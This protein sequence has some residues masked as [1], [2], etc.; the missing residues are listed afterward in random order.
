MKKAMK[1]IFCLIE[2]LVLPLCA[3]AQNDSILIRDFKVLDGYTQDVP[4]NTKVS[5]FEKDSV[6]LLADSMELRVMNGEVLGFY[7]YVP[8][9]A[10]YVL[11]VECK[12]YPTEW[13]LHHV[14][15]KGFNNA[16]GRQYY[17]DKPLY[18]WQVREQDLAEA[19][20]T[21]SKVLMV[22]KGDTIEYSAAAFRMS[23]G[24]ML[25]N[26]VAAMPGMAIDNE[27][28][29]TMNGEFVKELL[30]NGRDFFKGDPRVALS[31]LPAYTVNKI[32][33]YRRSEERPW[34]QSGR[35]EQEKREDPLVMNVKLKREYEQGWLSNYELAGG[36]GL[37][38]WFDEKWLARLFA[39]RYTNHSSIAIY[40]NA[41]NLN[42]ASSPGRKGEWKRTD[43][44][45]GEKQ[46]YMAGVDFSLSPKDTNLEFNT[47][48]QALR[49]QNRL[50]EEQMREDFLSAGNTFTRSSKD[51]R[52]TFT[53]LKWNADLK[54]KG[55]V[56][57]ISLSPQ[58]YYQH[59]DEFGC[60]QSL[61]SR[62]AAGIDTLYNRVQQAEGRE[63]R[64]GGSL[65]LAS[66]LSV[67]KQQIDLSA[68]V[69]YNKVRSDELQRDQIGYVYPTRRSSYE[70]R[71]F[72]RPASDYNYRLK[73]IDQDPRNKWKLAKGLTFRPTLSYAFTQQFNSGHQD[74]QRSKADWLTPS[75]Q[76]D[77]QWAVDLANSFH[78]TRMER[79]HEITVGLKL[80]HQKFLLDYRPAFV[81][82]QR[83]INDFRNTQ[84]SSR[85]KHDFLIHHWASLSFR[86]VSFNATIERELPGIYYLLDVRDESDPLVHYR[87]NAGLKPTIR[88]QYWAETTFRSQYLSRI[89]TAKAGYTRRRNA[90]SMAQLFDRT[91]N[92]TTYRPFNIDGNWQVSAVADYSQFL[93][94]GSHWH[95]SNHLEAIFARSVDFV[96]DNSDIPARQAVRNLKLKDELALR[97]QIHSLRVGA[98]ARV[99][100]T[101]LESRQQL[102]TRFSY[103]DFSC[104]VTLSTPIFR[105]VNLDT[106][107]MAYCRRGYNDAAMNTTDWVWNISLD[108]TLGKHKQ[109]TL[110]ATGFDLLRQLSNTLRIVNAQG[111]VETR[112]NTMP[113]YAML[114]VMYRLDVLPK[115]RK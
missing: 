42:D 86:K 50:G 15:K 109:W 75:A 69:A 10:D 83:R 114:H 40:A 58:L 45:A 3:Y 47:S 73:V 96:A 82:A 26:L 23:E 107:L 67:L 12:G 37:R 34:V 39:M 79:T 76:T 41:N 112:Y 102:F 59:R 14:R 92:V 7:A 85:R 111:R 25:D 35:T 66:F 89:F 4:R 30:V 11:R 27:G 6:T 81:F 70:G 65:G 49:Q 90:V 18:V 87:G 17:F 16:Y 80:A 91:T 77:E 68:R 1:D 110:K 5:V 21:G 61:K 29:I 46:S 104:G 115:K 93:D 28:R 51:G 44:S 24:S 48:M 84:P 19:T 54:Y 57:F 9:R 94:K 106:D 113:A 56:A 99:D 108:K 62:D 2:I 88:E 101:Q 105:G 103:V 60:Y 72:H 13:V 22:M 95:V 74:L 36:A 71:K 33:V 8:E 63:T 20:V 53:D 98:K 97:Y 32:Q 55:A 100:W 43:A 78:T 52:T 38:D 64:W 31:N